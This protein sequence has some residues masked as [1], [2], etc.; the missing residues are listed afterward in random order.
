MTERYGCFII[1]ITLWLT[2]SLLSEVHSILLSP[3]CSEP[4]VTERYLHD[5]RINTT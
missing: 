3:A 4:T 2:A 5:V 1:S